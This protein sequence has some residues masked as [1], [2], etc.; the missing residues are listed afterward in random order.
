MNISKKTYDE[1]KAKRYTFSTISDVDVKES[2]FSKIQ[3][4]TISNFCQFGKYTFFK[5]KKQLTSH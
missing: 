2:M 3:N 5:I 4:Y 1:R